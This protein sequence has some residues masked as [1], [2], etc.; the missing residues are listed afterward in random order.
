MTTPPP[1][2]DASVDPQLLADALRRVSAA[3][4]AADAVLDTDALHA[5]LATTTGVDVRGDELAARRARRTRGRW[6]QAAAAVAAFAVVGAGG[7][8]AGLNGDDKGTAPAISL[9]SAASSGTTPERDAASAEAWSQTT[10]LGGRVSSDSAVMWPG[11]GYGGNL[12]FHAQGLSQD[13]GTQAAW[14]FDA[15]SVY[16]RQ[17]AEKVA[18]AFG[19]TGTPKE[20]Y[21]WTVGPVDGSGA[22][23]SLSP[24]GQASVSYYDPTRDP[25][26]CEETRSAPDEPTEDQKAEIADGEAGAGQGDGVS[27]DDWG[28]DEPAAEPGVILPATAD[29]D[30][31]APSTKEAKAEATQTLST[32]GLDAAGFELEAAR[33]GGAGTSVSAYQVVDGQRT[34]VVWSFLVLEDGVQSASGPLAPLVALGDYDV[35]SPTEAVDRLN[36][37]RF[38]EAVTAYPLMAA[39]RET[40]QLSA[41][42]PE[43]SDDAVSP[44]PTVP[45]TITPGSDLSW[46]VSDVM[47]TDS[48]LGVALRTFADGSTALVPAYELRDDQG[49][50]W[51]VVAVVEAQLDF[52]S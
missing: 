10:A 7:Y 1:R 17:T 15:A 23:V 41:G 30:G 16:S 13:G 40:T 48:R 32:L 34:G 47:V 24:D 31:E 50:V 9:G 35:V 27:K 44:Q 52:S 18:D 51:S 29:C 25:W 5:T 12:V 36:D 37:P 26:S 4:P 42:V 49:G 46:P 38:G 21:G 43:S 45:P 8:A 11:H 2:D 20:D 33:D 14:A 6:L 19:V 3:D 28:T 22:S 39:A